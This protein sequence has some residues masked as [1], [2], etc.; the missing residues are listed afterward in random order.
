MKLCVLRFETR[1]AQRTF[2]YDGDELY[3][4][5]R[6]FMMIKMGQFL[7]LFG[8]IAAAFALCVF[9]SSPAQAMTIS[10]LQ[11]DYRV[12]EQTYT[13]GGHRRFLFANAAHLSDR[14]FD[15]GGC[16]HREK[17]PQYARAL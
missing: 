5:E 4:L 15:F 13:W 1:K 8:F 3:C 9:G 12:V 11:G 14:Q 6:M 16:S 10:D 17:M 2:P 7:R